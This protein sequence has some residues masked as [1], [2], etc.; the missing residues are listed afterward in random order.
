MELDPDIAEPA[1]DIAEPADV[2]PTDD[3]A[4][5]ADVPPAAPEAPAPEAPVQKR[6]RK[7]YTLAEKL[8]IVT[9]REKSKMTGRTFAESVGI[10]ESMIRRWLRDKEKLQQV[11][12]RARKVRRIPR[13]KVGM[14]PEVDKK[15]YEWV[16]TRNAQG[17]RVKDRF[18]QLQAL[19]MRDEVLT[20]T[21]DGPHKT[22]LEDF[23][24]S[25]MWLHRFKRRF[26][27]R[28]RRHTTTHTMPDDFREKAIA[29]VTTA[30]ELIAEFNISRDHIINLDQV[31]R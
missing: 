16:R 14:F 7:S 9:L 19:I 6:K 8:R 3:N 12:Q 26:N 27:L 29:L 5:P 4:E 21:D 11:F 18:L 31:P 28:S 23:E 2:P 22:A 20:T 25:K 15:V 13:P 30:Q 10:D 24:A 17:L 1:D